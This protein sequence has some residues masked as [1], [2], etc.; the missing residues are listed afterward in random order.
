MRLEMNIRLQEEL[1]V[2]K[3]FSLLI[4]TM[5]LQHG[6]L[7][8]IT[9]QCR[10]TNVILATILLRFV[11]RKVVVRFLQRTHTGFVSYRVLQTMF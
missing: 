10:S 9:K 11:Y 6:S 1:T 7:A 5:R 8:V 2:K 3:K 4:F